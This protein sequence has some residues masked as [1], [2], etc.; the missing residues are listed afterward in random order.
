M[1]IYFYS[2]R[3]QYGWMSNFYRSPITVDDATYPTTEH[4]FQSMKMLYPEDAEIVRQ[5]LTPA[6]AAKEGRTRTMRPDWD[7]V[8]IPV[9]D[10]ALEAKFTQH[11]HLRA[12]LL[13]TGDYILIEHTF[14]DKFWADGGDGSGQNQLGKALMRLRASLRG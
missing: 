3:D 13:A 9:M 8:R 12:K 6:L 1:S 11:P 14:K 5:A 7:E 2:T 4:Y 10:K